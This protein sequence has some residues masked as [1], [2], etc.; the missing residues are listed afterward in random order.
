MPGE[1]SSA[2][3]QTD[4]GLDTGGTKRPCSY[5]KTFQ[6]TRMSE[7]MSELQARTAGETKFI[8]KMTRKL[9][10]GWCDQAIRSGD[11]IIKLDPQDPYV[12]HALTRKGA[13]LST[14]RVP[15]GMF[16]I[17]NTGYQAAASFLS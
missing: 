9:L 11:P 4:A 7:N 5:D 16:R 3:G 10:V 8:D 1:T 2:L 13:F 15:P 14:K 6:M 12:Q 17:L